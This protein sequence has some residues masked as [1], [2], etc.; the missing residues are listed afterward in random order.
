M[1]NR[2][3]VPGIKMNNRL[4][5]EDS[6]DFSLPVVKNLEQLKFNKRVTFLYGIG[7]SATMK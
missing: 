4:D 2:L 6:Y 3:Y 5:K 1:N 7:S